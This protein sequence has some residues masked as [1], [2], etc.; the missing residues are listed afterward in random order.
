MLAEALEEKYASERRKSVFGRVILFGGVIALALYGLRGGYHDPTTSIAAIA[1]TQKRLKDRKKILE[2]IENQIESGD[3]MMIGSSSSA[4]AESESPESTITRSKGDA[5]SYG[6]EKVPLN[7]A[8]EVRQKKRRQQQVNSGSSSLTFEVR[9]LNQNRERDYELESLRSKRDKR[10]PFD[11][12][13]YRPATKQE[14]EKNPL[15]A[16]NQRFPLLSDLY[17]YVSAPV[18]RLAADAESYPDLPR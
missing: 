12:G 18:P 3:Q 9:A 1:Q 13:M 8:G 6:N 7:L 2:E 11:Y 16:R 4:D 10:P 14:S 5:D 17:Q 15:P